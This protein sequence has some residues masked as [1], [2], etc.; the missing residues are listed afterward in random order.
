MNMRG[1][2]HTGERALF[3]KH[4]PTAYLVGSLVQKFFPT[5]VLLELGMWMQKPD[6]PGSN[7]SSAT[8]VRQIASLCFMFS[9]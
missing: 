5:A 8:V 7:P 3:K 1:Q 4:L 9:I 2:G 6:W